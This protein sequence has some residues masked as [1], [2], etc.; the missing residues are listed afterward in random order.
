[1]PPIDSDEDMEPVKKKIKVM[2]PCRYG[3]NC[4]RKN[5]AHFKEYAHD[6][7]INPAA[8]P[9]CKYGAECRR[10][11]KQHLEDFDHP[12]PTPATAAPTAPASPE[13]TAAPPPPAPKA[14]IPPSNPKKPIVMLPATPSLESPTPSPALSHEERSPVVSPTNSPSTSPAAQPA[15]PPTMDL[16]SSGLVEERKM[17][18]VVPTTFMPA[19]ELVLA[20]DHG[21]YNMKYTHGSYYCTCVAWRFQ[22]KA[23]DSRTCKHLKEYLGEAFERARCGGA[24]P[25]PQQTAL[26]KRPMQGVLLA[27]KWNEKANMTGWWISEKLDGVRAYWN[28]TEF[29][30][31][32]GNVFTAPAWFTK[33][34]PSDVHFDGEL[35]GGRKQFQTTVSVVKSGAAH[36]GWNG[37][38]Y[39]VFDIPSFSGVWEKRMEKMVEVLS[40]AGDNIHVVDQLACTSNAHIDEELQRIMALG[41]E[42]LMLRQPASAYH[43][44]RSSTLQKVKKFCDCEARIK[45]HEPGKGKHTGRLGALLCELPSGRAFR[46]GTG[47]SDVQRENPPPIGAVI[48]VKYQELTN[49]GIPRFPVYLGVRIDATWP[50]AQ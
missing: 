27:E 47:F 30:S 37:I 39:E 15:D 28:G 43:R 2:V 14:F 18:G 29:L 25:T 38:K 10:Q 9:L 4:K 13:Y 20:G 7:G 34:M 48:T 19:E 40:G 49:G 50:P 41:G 22:N 16:S 5:A 26:A 35:F 1:M 24:A 8:K 46:C 6:A 32:N 21:Q 42:G 17:N 45:G 31:R 36:P 11:N 33:A 3:A 12:H 44:G 23:V